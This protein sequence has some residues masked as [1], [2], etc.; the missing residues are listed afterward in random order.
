MEQDHGMP[1]QTPTPARPR[2]SPS[3]HFFPQPSPVAFPKQ[4]KLLLNPV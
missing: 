2:L 1:M 3:G 4:R